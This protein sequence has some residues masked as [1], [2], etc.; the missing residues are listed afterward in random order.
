VSTPVVFFWWESME[1]VKL[2]AIK[3]DVHDTIDGMHFA[4]LLYREMNFF[5]VGL[6]E[7]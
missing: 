2:K 6:V 1:P 4:I 7:M 5:I 3:V